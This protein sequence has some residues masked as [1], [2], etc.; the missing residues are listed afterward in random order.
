LTHFIKL[1]KPQKT[2]RTNELIKANTT[3]VPLAVSAKYYI[4]ELPDGQLMQVPFT[5][6]QVTNQPIGKSTSTAH[7]E[8]RSNK[9]IPAAIL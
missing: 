9:K 1:L 2:D 3:L 7:N 5:N 4:A 8:N 6:V